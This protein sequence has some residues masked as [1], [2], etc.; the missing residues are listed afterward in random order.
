[1]NWGKQR[2]LIL[3]VPLS[4]ANPTSWSS[5]I[6]MDQALREFISSSL[7]FLGVASDVC[8]AYIFYNTC[9]AYTLLLLIFLSFFLLLLFCVAFQKKKENVY[10]SIYRYE[11]KALSLHLLPPFVFFFALTD[12]VHRF[13]SASVGFWHLLAPRFF[14]LPFPRLLL[15]KK[16][17]ETCVQ[18]C[19]F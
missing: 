11:R 9:F 4:S 1:M 8:T 18:K 2:D 12:Y 13:T 16:W 5:R 17:T 6:I 10:L 3:S 14:S 15:K 7:C 19:Y